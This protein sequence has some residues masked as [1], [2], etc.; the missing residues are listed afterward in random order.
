MKILA[1]SHAYTEPFTRAGLIEPGRYGDV[2]I[3]VVV[4]KCMAKRHHEGYKKLV[5]ENYDVRAVGTIFNFHNSVR[6][7]LPGLF[8]LIWGL[9]PDIIFINNEPWS[10]TAVQVVF[11]CSIFLPGTKVLIYTCENLVRKYPLPFRWMEKFVLKRAGLLLV[12]T[13]KEGEAVLRGK[14]YTGRV[15]YLPLSVDTGVFKKLDARELR[16]SVAG[17]SK[18]VI[19]YAGRIVREKGVDL[20]IEAAKKLSTDYHILIMGDGREKMAIEHL[21]KKYGII[22]RVSFLD[23]I[24]HERLPEYLNCLDALVL[25]S[26]TTPNWKEQFGRVLIEAM[27]C[28]VPVIGSSSGEIPNVVGDA[29]LIFEEGDAGSL[30]NHLKTLAEN[31]DLRKELGLKEKQRVDERFSAE[32]V[33]A[34]TYDIYRQVL[35]EKQ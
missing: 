6:K 15:A 27:A 1:I 13:E 32:K 12:I 17:D 26:R 7:Y 29:G 30:F 16:K 11:F 23:F 9:K 3:T 28:G 35:D 2:D 8:F 18:F 10:S 33:N 34:L 5:G 20:L 14:G 25:P 31:T 4:P 24:P 22:D 19:G 21:V